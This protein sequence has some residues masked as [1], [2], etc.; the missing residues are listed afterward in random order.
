MS[1][2]KEAFDI[3]GYL[4]KANNNS[5]I[6]IYIPESVLAIDDGAIYGRDI[7][8]TVIIYGKKG[9]EAETYAKKIGAKFIEE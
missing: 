7:D 8:K 6:S 4:N 9:S 3:N 2:E 1:V 5:V